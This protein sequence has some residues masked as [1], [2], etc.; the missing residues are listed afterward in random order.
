MGRMIFSTA[1][2]AGLLATVAFAQSYGGYRY[3]SGYNGD[4]GYQRPGV[5]NQVRADLERAASSSFYAHAQRGRFDHAL[6][7]LNRFEDRLRRGKFDKGPLDEVI[8]DTSHL[9]RAR[10]LEPRMRDMLARDAN[11]LRAFR[12]S[13]GYESY[14]GR[15]W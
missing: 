13:R 15:R 1:L 6:R 7:E 12:S 10:E 3:D 8:S 11:E 14:Y 4:H 5:I 2:G 9:S